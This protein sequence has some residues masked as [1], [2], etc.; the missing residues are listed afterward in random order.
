MLADEGAQVI[1]VEP[2]GGEL[3]RHRKPTRHAESAT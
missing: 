1:K 2:P 3:T